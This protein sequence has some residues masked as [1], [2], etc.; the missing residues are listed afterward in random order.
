MARSS[1]FTQEAADRICEEIVQGKSLRQLCAADDMPAVSTIFK[2]MAD[3]P[4]FSE[5]YA[6]AKDEQAELLADEIISIA[7]SEGDPQKARVKIDARKWVASKLK[8]KKYGD[9]TQLEH[10]GPDGGAIKASLTVEFV[11]SADTEGV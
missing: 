4:A 1:E 11:E 9:K 3:F 5:Q 8:P 7:D 2:W 10:S 6:R